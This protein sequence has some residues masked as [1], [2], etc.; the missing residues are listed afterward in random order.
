M[1]WIAI[2]AATIFL[3]GCNEVAKQINYGSAANSFLGQNREGAIT[4]DDPSGLP[5][6]ILVYL[7]SNKDSVEFSVNGKKI[8]EKADAMRV[9]L[10][11]TRLVISAKV[12]KYC[13]II[14]QVP[15]DT[16]SE[17]SEL[18]FH[19]GSDNLRRGNRC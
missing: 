3:S 2:A 8:G 15:K 9:L 5:S 17:G 12:E 11:N 16:I 6:N 18:R 19:F 14:K 13:P 10:P 7:R 4:Y 1:K